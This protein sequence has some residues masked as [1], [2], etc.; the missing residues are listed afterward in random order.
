MQDMLEMFR[1]IHINLPLFDAISQ[2]P[3]YARFL[4]ELCTKKRRSRKILDSILLSEE[5]SSLIQRRISEKLADPG[6][7]IIHCVI[8]HIRVER[9]L[10]ELGTSMNVLP[11]Y[12]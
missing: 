2:I 9:A 1:A 7:P 4:N 3:A 5:T 6:A 8:G 10:L 11:E 12:F